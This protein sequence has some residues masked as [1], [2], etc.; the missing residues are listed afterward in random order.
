MAHHQ[1]QKP[2]P[3][4]LKM[5]D[6]SSA[7]TPI[8]E[9]DSDKVL[10]QTN[11]EQ[12]HTK[13]LDIIL[14]TI[15]PHLQY[16][17]PHT[18]QQASP[19]HTNPPHHQKTHHQNSTTATSSHDTSAPQDQPPTTEIKTLHHKL[20][21]EDTRHTLTL[22]RLHKTLDTEHARHDSRTRTI[23]SRLIDLS[24]L[25]QQ[26]FRNLPLQQQQQP[27]N[28]DA[29][30]A[31]EGGAAN[32]QGFIAKW[33]EEL[34]SMSSFSGVRESSDGDSSVEVVAAKDA[35]GKGKGIR[36]VSDGIEEGGADD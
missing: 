2:P 5:I 32:K 13:D 8:P 11:Q 7:A 12:D 33:L 9:N 34:K 14:I 3:K 25:Q 26:H 16:I 31:V 22:T 27:T 17:Y 1:D 19:S 36:I 35:K 18:H 29:K 4:P 24:S 23:R 21:K 10:E 6:A 15:L 30:V 28:V 20:E